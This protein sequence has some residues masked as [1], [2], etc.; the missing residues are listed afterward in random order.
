[1][2]LV[3]YILLLIWLICIINFFV[4]ISQLIN[5]LFIFLIVAHLLECIIFYKKIIRSKEIKIKNFLLVMVFG[6]LHVQKLD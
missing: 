6:Y 2:N 1:M 3:K 4:P 5:Y